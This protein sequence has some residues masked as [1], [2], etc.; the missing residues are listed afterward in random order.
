MSL[1]R[2]F[3][4][5]LRVLG[6]RR[7][8]DQD[9]DDEV[10]HYLDE[11]AAA[12]EAQG[13]SR[14]EAR[15][16]ARIEIGTP[17]ALR[18]EVR[19]SGWENSIDTLLADLR[20][21]VRRLCGNPGFTAVSVLTLAMGIGATTAIFSVIEGVL[22]KPLPYLHPERL[23]ALRHAAPGINRS[24]LNL[25]A[26]L[27]FTYSEENRAFQDVAMW[28]LGSATITGLAEPEDV[29]A[30]WVTHEFLP[31]LE[32]QPVLG[33]RFTALDDSPAGERT[34]MLSDAW[35]KARFGG[36]PSVLGRRILIDG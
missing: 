1:W 3:T 13:L 30:L 2:Q 9:I 10:S 28:N 8:A 7:T 6:N 18:Q 14:D 22:W 29:P 16:A 25:S 27:Y 19:E 26:S 32:V 4:R 17:A 12:F 15:R 11:S 24:D 21:A 23:V 33:R 31:V 34:V 36:D 35:W 5:G 20:Y